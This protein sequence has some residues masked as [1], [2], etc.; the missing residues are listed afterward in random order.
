MKIAVEEHYTPES[1]QEYLVSRRG[2][3]VRRFAAG[4]S[5]IDHRLADMDA[6]KIDMQVL[7]VGI[8]GIHELKPED[9]AAMAKD[10][11]DEM[12]EVVASYPAKFAALA[13]IAPQ[14]PEQAAAELERAVK[15]L[16]MKG[17]LINSHINGE[18]LDEDKYRVIL[19]TASDLKVPLYIH[20]NLPSPDMIKPYLKYPI[21]PGAFWGFAAETGLHAMRLICSGV[22]DELPGLKIVLGHMGEALPFWLWRLDAQWQHKIMAAGQKELSRKPS[23]YIKDNFYFATSGMSWPLVIEFGCAAVGTD[24]ILFGVDYPIES[25]VVAVAAIENSALSNVDKEKIF[26]LN[27]EKVFNLSAFC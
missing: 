21:L 11:D 4:R 16:N 24:H 23:E 18:Y 13:A 19:K 27:A 3:A 12:A 17:A 9:G 20:P 5:S 10:I 22:F 1:L 15:K 2:E 8:M 26:H 25:N 6:A 7:S 14:G